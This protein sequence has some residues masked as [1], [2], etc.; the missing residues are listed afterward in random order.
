[1]AEYTFSGG[2]PEHS[3]EYL[4]PA[5]QRLLPAPGR[6]LD[7]GCGNGALC[8]RLAALGWGC[9]GV[10]VSESGIAAARL[11]PGRFEVASASDDLSRFGTFDLVT[12][13]EVVEH[14]TEPRKWAANVRACLRPGGTAIVSTPYHG[15]AKNLALSVLN[16]WDSHMSP[17]WD[18]GHIKLWSRRTLGRLLT[19][20]GFQDVRFH[21]V[22]R[23]PILAKSMIAVCR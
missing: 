5:V 22:G 13:L 21:R 23:V 1:M 17:L 6:V 8:G 4:W 2:A 9:V 12:S 11:N 19:E 16:R 10:D 18:C 7:I 15:Y 14:L 20:A 3:H